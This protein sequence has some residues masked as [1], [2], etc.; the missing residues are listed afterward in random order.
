M[1]LNIQ[2]ENME[3]LL[4][5]IIPVF[6]TG[7]FLEKC[8]D[9]I[10]D[11]EEFEVI[12][13]DDCSTDYETR[14]IINKICGFRK[15]VNAIF[16]EK[17]QKQ[18]HA[19]NVGIKNAKGKYITFV[20]SDDH[21]ER[22]RFTKMLSFRKNSKYEIIY[23]G[24]LFGNIERG[25]VPLITE[26]AIN[27]EV[28]I[29]EMK[30]RLIYNGISVVRAI[31]TTDIIK[32]YAIYFPENIFFEDNYW[33]PIVTFF[34][35]DFTFVKD[36]EYYYEK[37]DGQTTDKF[38]HRKL[39]DRLESARYL[40]EQTKGPIFK[41]LKDVFEARFI[42]L[43]FVNSVKMMSKPNCNFTNDDYDKMV[44]ELE[45]LCPDFRRNSIVN[46]D[47]SNKSTINKMPPDLYGF[48]KKM[49]CEFDERT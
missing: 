8:I 7:R 27:E 32:N 47:L 38:D 23:S 34:A 42:K 39:S 18:G 35:S 15:N 12:I 9:S 11:D 43:Y 4:S 36:C 22:G 26:G 48:I 2:G 25:Y 40:F 14:E 10:E 20:D 13:V 37:Y 5:V 31:Y 29:V 41:A 46:Q 45:N 3:K 19:R 21:F 30:K 17:N 49:Y 44:E 1:V 28:E 33:V 16:L 6:N 24:L